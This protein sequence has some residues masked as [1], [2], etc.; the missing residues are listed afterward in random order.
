MVESKEEQKNLLM[1]VK[2][3]SEKSGLKTLHS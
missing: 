2:E 3:D 1:R